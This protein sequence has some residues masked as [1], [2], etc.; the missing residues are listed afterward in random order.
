[1]PDFLDA[2]GATFER[3]YGIPNF[4]IWVVH[5]GAFC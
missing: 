1:M 3:G 4:G 2:F 5:I